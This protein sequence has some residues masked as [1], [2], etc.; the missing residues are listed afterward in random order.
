MKSVINSKE[1]P[2]PIGPYSHSTKVKGLGLLFVSGQLGIDPESNK[3]V[4]EEIGKQAKQSLENLKS[5]LK[6]ANSSL[7]EVLK[8]TV[9]LKD[10][11]DFASF[12]KIYETYFVK[13]FP[14]RSCI[15]VS[16]LPMAA[17]IEIEAIAM[18]REER[19][20]K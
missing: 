17:K 19:F 9:F 10:M 6:T 3:L 16:K 18:C 4:G 12:N 13:E 20:G 11:N 7:D 2:T 5:I 14:S 1:A 8:V 15:E